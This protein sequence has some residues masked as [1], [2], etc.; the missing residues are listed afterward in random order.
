MAMPRLVR[1]V[2]LYVCTLDGTVYSSRREAQAAA[3]AIRAR[4]R[5]ATKAR[6]AKRAGTRRGGQTLA[7]LRA[8]QSGNKSAADIRRATRV[9]PQ[10]VHPILHRLKQ[11]R[12]VSG[13]AGT[14]TLTAAGKRKA[15]A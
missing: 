8:I 15:T 11:R 1:K 10:N 14:Y 6:A 13:H 2:V 12:L 7:I 4:V 5:E 3:L 9:P